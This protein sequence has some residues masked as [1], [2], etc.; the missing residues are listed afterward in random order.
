M[1]RQ[2]TG[3]R[4]KI[5]AS[6]LAATACLHAS[7]STSGFSINLN[8]IDD[9]TSNSP[10]ASELAAFN[11]AKATW[12][13]II[14]GFKDTIFDT[15]L[16]ID[17]RLEA[18]DGV[19]KVLGSAGPEFGKTGVENNFLYASSGRMRFDTADTADLANDGSLDD[20]ILHELAHVIGLGTLWSSSDTGNPGFQELIDPNTGHYIGTAAVAAYN[21]EFGQTDTFIPVEQAGGPGTAGGHWDE[22]DNGAG[23]TGITNSDGKDFRNELMTGWLNAPTFISDAT[24]ASFE[25][26]GYNTTFTVIPTPTAATAGL[27]ALLG[28]NLRR[29]RRG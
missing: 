19:G 21:A 25:D 7:A 15:T 26:L 22:V 11:A 14:T 9:A 1:K 27:V 24:I 20:V 23:L 16:E 6:A 3:T 4:L 2:P 29:R 5:T 12:E 18:I 8:F 10:T 28:L 13:G 17:V